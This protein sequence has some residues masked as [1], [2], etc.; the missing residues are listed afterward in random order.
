MQKNVGES[1]SKTESSLPGFRQPLW[2]VKRCRIS[3]LDF[4]SK[5]V[6]SRMLYHWA[7][8]ERFCYR[9]RL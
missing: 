2:L 8:G 1:E 5:T 9:P 7:T 6:N 3:L 4:I